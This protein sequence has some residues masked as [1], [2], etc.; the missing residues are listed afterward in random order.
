GDSFEYRLVV[1]FTAGG[2]L[3]ES[4]KLK[5]KVLFHQQD[6]QWVQPPEVVPTPQPSG[7]M[8]GG[9]PGLQESTFA[10]V[11]LRSGIGCYDFPGEVLQGQGKQND[12]IDRGFGDRGDNYLAVAERIVS[13][14][15]KLTSWKR[16]AQSVRAINRRA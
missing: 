4:L 9:I 7:I 16:I 14:I 15:S 12:P 1:N 2:I 8:L 11:A 13:D 10:Y 6:N 5:D 3:D